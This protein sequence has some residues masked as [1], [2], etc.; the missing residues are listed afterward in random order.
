M[1]DYLEALLDEETKETLPHPKRR[2]KMA[3]GRK[4][5]AEEEKSAST[6]AAPART[7]ALDETV[8]TALGEIEQ[9]AD[10]GYMI[11]ALHGP[12]MAAQQNAP[13]D[14][15]NWT[16][17]QTGGMTPSQLYEALGRTARLSRTAFSGS[18]PPPTVL[19]VESTTGEKNQDWEALDRA[20]QRDARRYDGGFS[21]Y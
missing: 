8:A 4:S 14:S 2:R 19:T 20:V 9:E 5:L 15:L 11:S 10:T 6:D 12:G 1:I 7:V 3:L 18:S 16:T 13:S 21:L 17:R